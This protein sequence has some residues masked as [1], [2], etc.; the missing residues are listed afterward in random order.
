M[1]NN[2]MPRILLVSGTV[3]AVIILGLFAAIKYTSPATPA[4][5]KKIV[6]PFRAADYSHLPSLSYYQARDGVKLAYRSYPLDTSSLK[7]VV[8]IHGSTGSSMM[9]H[10]LA[11]YLQ[12]QGVHVYVPDMRGHGSSGEKG[13]ITY[14][15]Q[16]EDDLE[17]FIL[18]V[19]KDKADLTLVGFSAGGG[20]ALRFAAGD[21]QNYFDRY[22]LLAPFL[23]Y[24]SPTTRPE[25]SK[26]ASASI[27]RIVCLSLLG[28]VGEKAFGHLP[29]LAFGVDPV[30]AQHQTAVYSYR[31][32]KNFGAHYNYQA[33]MKNAQKPLA[34]M[35]GSDDELFYPQ[36]FLPVFAA[37]Q[38]HAEITI[39]PGVGHSLLIIDRNAMEAIAQQIVR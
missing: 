39:V 1:M 17:D 22:L 18:E 5:Y 29:V 3:L 30:N 23:R 37:D 35:V 20:F 8:L 9:M 16:M 25:D 33:D 32:W 27:P 19:L 6:E 13:D 36:K 26:W 38:P 7:A 28:P 15:G 4:P 34:V 24:D 11:Q 14:V 2:K 10:P 12:G 31:L 21:R